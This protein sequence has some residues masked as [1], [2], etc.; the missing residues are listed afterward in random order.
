[1]FTSGAW[2]TVCD[3]DWDLTDANVVCRYL[4]FSAAT[5]FT[6]GA[7]FG[8]GSGAI[9]LDNVRCHGSESSIFECSSNGI[10]IHDCGHN[11]DAGVRCQNGEFTIYLG[12]KTV[13]LLRIN[14][15]HVIPS[16]TK[17]FLLLFNN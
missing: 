3:D 17:V 16:F 7:S 5:D 9:I 6:S 1:M 14:Q 13:T 4:G 11:E 8:Q 12:S 2:G 15:F 10:G